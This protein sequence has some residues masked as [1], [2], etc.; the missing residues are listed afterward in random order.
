MA[1]AS[2]GALVAASL[3][4]ACSGLTAL[5]DVAANL[6]ISLPDSPQSQPF[7]DRADALTPAALLRAMRKVCRLA[8]QR[9][10]PTKSHLKP[11]FLA[12]AFQL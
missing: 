2:S 8:F 12:S 5:A 9:A 10:P 3:P 1:K 11:H 4:A 7:L 6:F